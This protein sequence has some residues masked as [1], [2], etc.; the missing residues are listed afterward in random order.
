M[1]RRGSVARIQDGPDFFVALADH[2]EWGHS[3]TVWGELVGEAGMRTLEAIARLPYHEQTGAG[4]TIMRLLDEEL[5][6]SGVVTRAAAGSAM[7]S[8]STKREGIVTAD[9]KEH[10][11]TSSSDARMSVEL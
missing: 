1:V 10:P 2:Q 8:T 11:G 5:P 6:A 7:N 4:G 9:G 3:F